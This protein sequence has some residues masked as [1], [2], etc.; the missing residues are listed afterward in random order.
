MILALLRLMSFNL[1]DEGG[2]WWC[3]PG[4]S[5][6]MA[7][8]YEGDAWADGGVFCDLCIL[9]GLPDDSREIFGGVDLGGL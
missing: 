1:R 6:E 5:E 3:H 2:S 4:R 8:F 9:S 7:I